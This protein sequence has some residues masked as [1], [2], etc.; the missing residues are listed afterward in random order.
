MTFKVLD[1]FSGTQSVKKGL[2]K[3]NIDFEYYGIDIYSPEEENIILDLS[4]ENI[5]EKL[6]KKL[7]EGWH[8]DFIWA[9]PVC[10]K[11]SIASA[12]KGGNVYFEKIK[13]GI[14]IR[15]NFK[16]L[17]NSQYKN[18]DHQEAINEAK[19]AIKLVQNMNLIIKYYNCDFVIENP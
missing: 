3:M 1:L 4:E 6:K 5:V 13:N 10:D 11:F 12:V 15:E 8:P 7:P 18:K 14:K 19:F 17:L 16:P 2:K 9:S